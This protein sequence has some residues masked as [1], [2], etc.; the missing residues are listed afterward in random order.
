[1]E[2]DLLRLQFD[3][4]A[5]TVQAVRLT[6]KEL[7]E[8]APIARLSA[9][10]GIADLDDATASDRI[11]SAIGVGKDEVRSRLHRR[12]DGSLLELLPVASADPELDAALAELGAVLESGA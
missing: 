9:I 11:A 1:V 6:P 7:N 5:E 2:G 10:T 8:A 12:G 3:R 4:V